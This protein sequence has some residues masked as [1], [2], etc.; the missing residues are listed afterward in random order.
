MKTE[1]IIAYYLMIDINKFHVTIGHAQHLR[2]LISWRILFL[3]LCVLSLPWRALFMSLNFENL[4]C[5]D[6]PSGFCLSTLQAPLCASPSAAK[7]CRTKPSSNYLRL[8]LRSLG[9]FQRPLTLRLLQK[10]KWEA[11]RDTT[12][13]CGKTIFLAKKKAYFCK[14]FALE[15]GGVSGEEERKKIERERERNKQKKERK[16]EERDELERMTLNESSLSCDKTLQALLPGHINQLQDSWSCVSICSQLWVENNWKPNMLSYHTPLLQKWSRKTH[17]YVVVSFM[18]DEIRLW[19][20]LC[21]HFSR[22]WWDVLVTSLWN[23]KAGSRTF[24]QTIHFAPHA[25]LQRPIPSYTLNNDFVHIL[26]KQTQPST[27]SNIFL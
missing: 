26:G 14:H 15:M 8:T 7:H 27:T 4:L 6:L 24:I 3:L 16:R 17:T 25:K 19:W 12:W 13:W 21:A 5:F 22:D 2:R 20:S 9:V 11:Y 10:Y 23:F 1:N 18:L